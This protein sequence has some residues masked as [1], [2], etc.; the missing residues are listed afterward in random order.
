MGVAFCRGKV[1]SG[2]GGGRLRGS[3]PASTPAASQRAAAGQ[4]QS[5]RSSKPQLPRVSSPGLPRRSRVGP[6][7]HTVCARRSLH[8][9]G[10]SGKRAAS[11]GGWERMFRGGGGKRSGPCAGA[12]TLLWVRA[13]AALALGARAS[14]EVVG[15]TDITLFLGVGVTS[16]TTGSSGSGSG[17]SSGSHSSPVAASIGVSPLLLPVLTRVRPFAAEPIAAYGPEDLLRSSRLLCRRSGGRT[18]VAA[19]AAGAVD[20]CWRSAACWRSPSRPCGSNVASRDATVPLLICRTLLATLS[21]MA[22]HSSQ[23]SGSGETIR[24]VTPAR[25]NQAAG[26]SFGDMRLALAS[27][28]LAAPGVTAALTGQVVSCPS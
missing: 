14:R 19:A 10:G 25:R 9:V 2:G 17:S 12:D 27:L 6:E 8:A 28:L 4:Q 24:L 18:A 26:P 23:L 16:A 13:R 7:C 21:R 3:P 22:P 1:C 5:T 20:G 11:L 15:G